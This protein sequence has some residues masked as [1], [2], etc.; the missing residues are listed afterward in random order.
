MYGKLGSGTIPSPPNTVL[1]CAF[2]TGFGTDSSSLHDVRAYM[3][4]HMTPLSEDR[5]HVSLGW[6]DTRKNRYLLCKHFLAKIVTFVISLHVCNKNS[7]NAIFLLKFIYHR[8]SRCYPRQAQPGIDR[9]NYWCFHL[10]CGLCHLD[11]VNR[12]CPVIVT[13]FNAFTLYKPSFY[14]LRRYK[15][16]IYLAHSLNINQF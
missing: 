13:V 12:N 16:Q 3:W 2:L 15:R 7:G 9:N 14:Y 6:Q 10:A 8:R 5:A 4:R 1:R 11:V